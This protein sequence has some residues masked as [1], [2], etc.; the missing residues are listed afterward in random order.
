MLG[1]GDVPRYIGLTDKKIKTRLCKRY[2]P[3]IDKE[4]KRPRQFRIAEILR[5][6]YT[7]SELNDFYTSFK[8]IDKDDLKDKFKEKGLKIES[9]VRLYGALDFARFK[10]EEIWFA[11]IPLEDER[12]KMIDEYETLFIR[13]AIKYN[14]LHKY[15]AL[16]NKQ[17]IQ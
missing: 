10:R 5:N 6:D 15:P 14:A 13:S 1:A 11:C 9:D 8:T 16:L 12:I 17:K 3:Y 7:I 4:Y 2:V